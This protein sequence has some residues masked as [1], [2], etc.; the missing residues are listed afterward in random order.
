MGEMYAAKGRSVD[1]MDAEILQGLRRFNL[2]KIE[3][4]EIIYLWIHPT[5]GTVKNIWKK[6]AV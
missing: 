4:Y 1:N 5:E 6:A 3:P 2:I